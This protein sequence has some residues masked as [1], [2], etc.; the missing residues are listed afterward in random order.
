[1]VVENHIF[2]EIYNNLGI[3]LSAV[4]SILARAYDSAL[5]ILKIISWTNYC[6]ALGEL[7]QPQYVAN[8]PVTTVKDDGIR[9]NSSTHLIAD[10]GIKCAR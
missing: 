4:R 7:S 9:R 10:S 5:C 1:M 2:S 3:K 6:S 8:G